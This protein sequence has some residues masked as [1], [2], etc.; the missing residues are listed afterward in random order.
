MDKVFGLI[1]LCWMVISGWFHYET[2]VQLL[3]S[4]RQVQVLNEQM[5]QMAEQMAAVHAEMTKLDT[6]SIDGM[7]R[8]ANNALISGWESLVNTVGEE[9]KKAR[10]SMPQDQ[11]TPKQSPTLESPDGTD[12]I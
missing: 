3:D 6:Q 7:V 1:L 11:A 10:E 4:Q 5:G 9:L 2:R 12:R 8:D